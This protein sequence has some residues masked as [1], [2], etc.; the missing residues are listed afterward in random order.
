MASLDFLDTMFAGSLRTLLE[1]PDALDGVLKHRGV[2]GT[3]S[4]TYDAF[5]VII[6]RVVRVNTHLSTGIPLT[7]DFCSWIQRLS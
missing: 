3:T 1:R 2:N 7:S 4:R 6:D 5:S